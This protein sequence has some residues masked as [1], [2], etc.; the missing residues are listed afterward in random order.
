MTEKATQKRP[1]IRLRWKLVQARRL[2]HARSF[3]DGPLI[4]FIRGSTLGRWD[5]FVVV[6]RAKWPDTDRRI[7]S[8]KSFND[9]RRTVEEAIFADL[10]RKETT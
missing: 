10:N 2:W 1:R 6:P 7:A 5:C 8:C 3:A 4:G 9:A